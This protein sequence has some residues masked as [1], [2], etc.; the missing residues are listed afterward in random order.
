MNDKEGLKIY[1]EK[2]SKNSR[3][4]KQMGKNSYKGILK[5]YSYKELAK[6]F[7]EAAR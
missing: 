5:N 2:L 4:R 3:L 7:L 1:I 6:E